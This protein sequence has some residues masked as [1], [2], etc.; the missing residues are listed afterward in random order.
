MLKR[1][2]YFINYLLYYVISLV[3]TLLLYII[4][5]SLLITLLVSEYGHILQVFSNF[6]FEVL[7]NAL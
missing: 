2:Y 1:K 6:H 3:F 5:I 4:I 7:R